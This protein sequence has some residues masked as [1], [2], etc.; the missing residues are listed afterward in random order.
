MYTDPTKLLTEWRPI[1]NPK[2]WVGFDFLEKSL[3]IHQGDV[4]YV[5]I[6]DYQMHH[7]VVRMMTWRT[8]FIF[9]E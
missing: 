4:E 8:F 5:I 9:F 3:E 6:P 2:V 1:L 7:A